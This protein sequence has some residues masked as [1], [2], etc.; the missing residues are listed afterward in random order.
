M[1]DV[2]GQ[3]TYEYSTNVGED[4]FG[5]HIRNVKSLVVTTKDTADA[6]DTLDVDM[7]EYGINTVLGIDGF[8]HTTNNSV[9]VKEN[10][11]TSVSSGTLTI[12]VPA[13]SDNDMRVYKILYI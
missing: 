11:T 7:S 13:G 1:A 3:E 2:T 9:I 8:K 5:N 6:S 4:A 10:P 12:T